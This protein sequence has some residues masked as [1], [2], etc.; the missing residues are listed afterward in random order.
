MIRWLALGSIMAACGDNLHVDVPEPCDSPPGFVHVRAGNGFA[1]ALDA[2]GR[3]SCWGDDAHHQIEIDGSYRWDQLE[4][5]GAHACGILHDGGTLACFGANDRGQIDLETEGDRIDPL[6]VPIDGVSA[7]TAVSAG[8]H[9]SCAIGDGRLWCWGAGDS[10][11]L[12]TASANDDIPREPR[13]DLT[14]WIAVTAGDNHTCAISARSGLFC[15]GDNS[16]GELGDGTLF[17]HQTPVPIALAQPVAIASGA[18]FTCGISAD[19]SLSCW[20]DG[21]SGALGELPTPALHPRPVPATNLRG[22]RK[23]AAANAYACGL[24]GG[25][26]W[27]WGSSSGG[28]VGAGRWSETRA[29]TR[30]LEGASDLAVGS[31]VPG[32]VDLTCAIVGRDVRCWGDDRFGQLGT[33]AAT[34][35]IEPV[36]VDGTWDA[37][38]AGDDH[39]CATRAGQVSCWGATDRGQIDGV[40]HGSAATPCVAGADCDVA[41]ARAIT[42]GG[43]IATGSAFTCSNDGDAITCWGEDAHGQCGDA[44]QP[45]SPPRVVTGVTGTI[46]AGRDGACALGTLTT[47]W[48]RVIS[49]HAAAHEPTLDNARAL[50]LGDGFGCAIGATG[51]L[52]CWGDLSGGAG[53]GVGRAYTKIAIGGER[54]ACGIRPDRRVECWGRNERGQAGQPDPDTFLVDP[55]TTPYE[56]PNLQ[57]CTAIA[58]GGAHTCAICSGDLACWG[59]ATLGQLGPPLEPLPVSYRRLISAPLPSGETWIDLAAGASFTCARST[60]GRVA[61]WGFSAHGALGTG[62]LG[63]NLPQSVSPPAVR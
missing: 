39:V 13:P 9:H 21:T 42:T 43:T 27:C 7:W 36:F 34:Q 56:Q 5:G 6:R 55:V 46:E 52:A 4:L 44:A 45:S 25:D 12:G 16:H 60:A 23:I 59:D 37:I 11:Q 53:A 2:C 17:L 31:N 14:D 30:V 51:T 49:E 61:C 20:G 40:I 54:F 28:G 50:A 47:C 24:V 15:W 63:A 18:T 48:G 8:F 26:V 22:W 58:T 33:G 19:G 10:G 1:C 62:G 32:D 38:A 29:W 57:G 3:A 41:R 35:A